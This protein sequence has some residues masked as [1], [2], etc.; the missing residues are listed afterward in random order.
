MSND[1][2]SNP[3]V[4]DTAGTTVLFPT[5]LKISHFEFVEYTTKTH[6]A[7]IQGTDGKVKWSAI[8]ETDL[9]PISS[10]KIGWITGL[11]LSTLGSGRVLV[12][13]E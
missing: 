5:K 7:I 2:S 8:G 1:V 10:H 11:V 6:T 4:L 12:Y 13:I 9:D 3:M